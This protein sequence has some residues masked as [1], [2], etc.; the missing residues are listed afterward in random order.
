M[1]ELNPCP[2]CGAT[3]TIDDP[4][5]YQR[6]VGYHVECPTCYLQMWAF[7]KEPPDSLI[8]RWN[9][10]RPDQ[11]TLAILQG[12]EAALASSYDVLEYPASDD[13]KQARALAAIRAKVYGSAV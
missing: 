5:A 2:F 6:G 3:V 7:A 12:A 13:S 1:S 4:E 8:A 11:E 9:A 10:R